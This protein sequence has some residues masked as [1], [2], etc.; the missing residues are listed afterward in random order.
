MEN[1]V[2][3]G[4]IGGICGVL[5]CIFCIS[6]VTP[7]FHSTNQPN[8]HTTLQ[9][10][11]QS[12]YKMT[13]LDRLRLCWCTSTACSVC[14][15]QHC[16]S[17]SSHKS[18]ETTFQSW[19]QCVAE[20]LWDRSQLV[21]VNNSESGEMTLQFGVPPGLYS[22]LGPRIFKLQRMHQ[23]SSDITEYDI[24]CLLTT[25]KANVVD[26]Q[27]MLLRQSQQSHSYRNASPFTKV[28]EWCAAKCL[29]LNAVKRELLW[30]GSASQL[31]WLSSHFD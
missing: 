23:T 16:W 20:F 19:Q 5:C 7:Y 3:T 12:A 27:V 30:F 2:V 29:Q 6:V 1:S 14:C 17:S 18:P 15:L 25:C 22:V 21:H 4:G 24:I 11:L 10:Q 31:H 9:R 13:R 26:S 28:S 8:V